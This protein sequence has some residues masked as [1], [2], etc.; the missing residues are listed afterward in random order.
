MNTGKDL[1]QIFSTNTELIGKIRKLCYELDLE[2]SD[3]IRNYTRIHLE[4]SLNCLER[5]KEWELLIFNSNADGEVE[6]YL[7]VYGWSGDKHMDDAME[8]F[9]QLPDVKERCKNTDDR[10]NK[11]WSY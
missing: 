8:E 3:Y 2:P 7:E 6:N 11:L 10:Y 4:Q 5:H 1:L 9:S